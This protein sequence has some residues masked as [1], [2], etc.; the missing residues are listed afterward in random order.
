[1]AR[2]KASVRPAAVEDESPPLELRRCPATRWQAGSASAAAFEEWLRE[3]QAWRETHTVPLPR[4][5]GRDRL[6]LRAPAGPLD[7]RLVAAEQAAAAPQPR[8]LMYQTEEGVS[9]SQ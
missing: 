1:M 2:R 9:H 6:A 8:P 5:S 4:L 3:R 7:P